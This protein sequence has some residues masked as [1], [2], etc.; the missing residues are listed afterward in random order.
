MKMF[1]KISNIKNLSL[2]KDYNIIQI[3]I[4]EL[5][6]LI[7]GTLEASKLRYKADWCIYDKI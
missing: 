3:K 7:N 2:K 1:L 5:S 6:V 4:Y